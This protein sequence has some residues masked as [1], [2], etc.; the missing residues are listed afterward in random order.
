MNKTPQHHT[1]E[2]QHDNPAARQ[3]TL[4]CHGSSTPYARKKQGCCSLLHWQGLQPS[5][6]WSISLQHLLRRSFGPSRN[7]LPVIASR[8]KETIWQNKK[9]CCQAK[10]VPRWYWPKPHREASRSGKWNRPKTIWDLTPA[11]R[12][13]CIAGRCDSIASRTDRRH[14]R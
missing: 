6:K 10:S 3:G 12:H 4:R 2:Q 13:E 9:S 8:L 1:G 5:R 14:H 11:T 7:C